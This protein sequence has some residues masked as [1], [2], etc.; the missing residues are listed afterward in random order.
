MLD[1]GIKVFLTVA[2]TRSFNQAAVKLFIS[3]TAVM[4]R[5]NQ[6]ENQIGVK[7]FER[8]RHGVCLTA[9]GEVFCREME[10]LSEEMN[11]ALLKTLKEAGKAP[12]IVRV[13]NSLRHPC[14]A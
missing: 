3:P 9:A 10:R 13:G 14:G 1:E 2:Q 5:I 4:K 6:L 7:L 12:C 11:R 8:T